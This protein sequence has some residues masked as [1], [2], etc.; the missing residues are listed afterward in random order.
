MRTNPTLT[1]TAS[2]WLIQDIASAAIDLT[3]IATLTT[4]G[5]SRYEQTVIKATVAAGLIGFRPY[6]LIGDGTAGRTLVLSAEL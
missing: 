1:A 2:D 5:Y 3:A 6:T 4:E